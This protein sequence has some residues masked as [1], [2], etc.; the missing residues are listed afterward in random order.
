MSAGQEGEGS[1]S[2]ELVPVPREA[3]EEVTLCELR[4]QVP[5]TSTIPLDFAYKF[6]DKMIKNFHT[7]TAER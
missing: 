6:N 7:V 4:V 3:T 1:G 2:R 5:S